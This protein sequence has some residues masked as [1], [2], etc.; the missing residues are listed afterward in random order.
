MNFL[1]EELSD[2]RLVNK[3]KYFYENI[4]YIVDEFSEENGYLYFKDIVD[5]CVYLF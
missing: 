2:I 3:E 4:K 1:V 5:K